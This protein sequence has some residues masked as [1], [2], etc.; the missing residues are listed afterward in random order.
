MSPVC[1]NNKN[2]QVCN[3]SVNDKNN[4][5]RTL[6]K[7]NTV[8]QSKSETELIE[9]PQHTRPLDLRMDNKTNCNISV[10]EIPETKTEVSY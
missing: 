9:F 8:K 4:I 5:L 1:S 7:I 3:S 6:E 10:P 2:L